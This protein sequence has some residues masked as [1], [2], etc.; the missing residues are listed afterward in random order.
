VSEW[1]PQYARWLIRRLS[2]LRGEQLLEMV[3]VL[4]DVLNNTSLILLFEAGDQKLLFPGD[5]QLENWSYAL[6]QGS[7][8]D[9]L[10]DATLYKVGHHGSRNATPK[11][12]WTM[13]ENKKL[14]AIVS[15][16]PGKHGKTDRQTE[17]PRAT[18][19]EALKQ[20]ELHSTQ[21]MG[22]SLSPQGEPPSLT[23]SLEPRYGGEISPTSAKL[24]SGTP[25][26]PDSS[27]RTPGTSRSRHA[28]PP[29][30]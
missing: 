27:P 8:R 12:M 9:L 10:K 26:P 16:K 21:D 25:A 19:I 5:A 23:V 29:D 17:V 11:S 24:P 1:T 14:K 28:S 6:Q 22:W 2:S 15:T 18:L 30:R 13:I 20:Y 4:D 3:R 7:T